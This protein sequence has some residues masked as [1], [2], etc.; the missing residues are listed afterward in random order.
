MT[1]STL[2]VAIRSRLQTEDAMAEGGD[3]GPRM[4]TNRLAIGDGSDGIRSETGDDER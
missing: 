3:E 1:F 4:E 2:H